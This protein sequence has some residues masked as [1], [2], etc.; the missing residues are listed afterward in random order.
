MQLIYYKFR[1]FCITKMSKFLTEKRTCVLVLIVK[2][3]NRQRKFWQCSALEWRLAKRISR[4]LCDWF[5]QL[6]ITR[7]LLR[8]VVAVKHIICCEVIR[9]RERSSQ[10]INAQTHHACDFLHVRN[11]G[12]CRRS[13]AVFH[14]VFITHK[15]AACG[16]VSG[17]GIGSQSRACC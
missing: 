16:I 14:L 11:G 2:Q 3:G 10:T 12:S 8:R 5:N 7:D 13:T 1:I 9:P 17:L 6:S 4:R 15:S